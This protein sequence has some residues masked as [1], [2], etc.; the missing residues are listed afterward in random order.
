[1]GHNGLGEVSDGLPVKGS[2]T[3]PV[4]GAYVRKAHNYETVVEAQRTVYLGLPDSLKPD[5]HA[6]DGVPDALT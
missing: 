6:A 1:M 3:P 5:V 2:E 4:E